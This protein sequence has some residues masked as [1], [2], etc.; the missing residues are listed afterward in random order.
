MTTKHK[1]AGKLELCQQ[2]FPFHLVVDDQFILQQIGNKINNFHPHCKTKQSFFEFFKILKPKYILNFDDLS[3]NANNLFILESSVEEKKFRLKAQ[4]L[5]NEQPLSAIIICVPLVRNTYDFIDWNLNLSDFPFHDSL[6]DYL[7]LLQAQQQ[8]LQQASELTLLLEKQKKYLLKKNAELTELNYIISHD[9]KTPIRGISSLTEWLYDD[10][11]EQLDDTAKEYLLLLKKRVIRVHNLIESLAKYARIEN[12]NEHQEDID[13][14]ELIQ[15]I[16]LDR[17][18]SILKKPYKL[19]IKTKLPNIINE[20][21]K[22]YQLFFNL[23][24]IY[25]LISNKLNL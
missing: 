10:Y 1:W 18:I 2:L 23:I 5:L 15:K 3:Q 16:K 14:N 22:I 24:I 11:K 9:L 4:I 7:F 6:P 13:L 8:S 25:S 12:V 19:L 20:S 17:R 21:N